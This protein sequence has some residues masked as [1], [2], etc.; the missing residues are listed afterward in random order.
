M[1]N[2]RRSGSTSRVDEFR[3]PPAPTGLSRGGD[4]VTRSGPAAA[5]PSARKRA[6]GR[7][8]V[9]ARSLPGSVRRAGRV[10]K[11]NF[12]PPTGQ[13]RGDATEQSS[14]RIHGPPRQSPPASPPSA[15]RPP[16]SAL[17]SSPCGPRRASR[18]PPL[19]PPAPRPP[20]RSGPSLRCGIPHSTFRVPPSECSAFRVP[21]S[22]HSAFRVPHSEN[23][24]ADSAEKYPQLYMVT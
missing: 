15:L 24:R 18:P 20:P 7:P 9:H 10:S 3:G 1:E 23:A 21:H 2:G 14:P 19:R 12:P 11:T 16:I 22:K 17:P 5:H 4:K 8:L 13:A 6:R